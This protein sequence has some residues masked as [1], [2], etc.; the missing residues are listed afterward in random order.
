MGLIINP[1]GSSGSGKTE[2]V[3]QILGAYGWTRNSPGAPPGIRPIYR[4]GRSKPF[5][6]RLQH[7]RGEC[8]L[9]VVGHYEATSGGCDTI[10]AKD[11]GMPEIVRRARDFADRGHDVVIEGLRLSS[12]VEHSASLAASHRLHILFLSTPI[13]QCVRNLASRR[14]VGR[15]SFPSIMKR[16]SEEHG[17]VMEACERLRRHSTVE[18]F[19][20]DQALARMR[21]LLNLADSGRELH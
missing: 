14:R 6:Y 9:F 7:P 18:V 8:P 3:R 21:E 11:G 5:A 1:R 19:D 13:E 12:E 20:F 2:L 17:R 15:S 10:R 4:E 16:T